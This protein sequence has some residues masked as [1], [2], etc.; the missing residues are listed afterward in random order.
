MLATQL[1]VIENETAPTVLLKVSTMKE[2]P[3]LFSAPMVR[4]ILDGTKTQ[5]RRVVKPQPY[6]N[7]HGYPR[8]DLRKKGALHGL[9]AASW[10][11]MTGGMT[12]YCPYGEVGDRLWVRETFSYYGNG[13]EKGID[14]RADKLCNDLNRGW[15]PSIFMPRKASR[16]TL[17]ITN[18]LVERLQEISR[19]DALAEGVDRTNSS[20]YDYPKEKYKMLWEQINGKGSWDAN[21]WVWVVKFTRI[22]PPQSA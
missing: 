20:I 15:K 11:T 6:E 3:I 2:R 1:A 4:A 16:I 19:N 21:P 5:T 9:Q 7:N 17:E 18:I 22:E 10:A 14:Y 12:F 13:E 8:W